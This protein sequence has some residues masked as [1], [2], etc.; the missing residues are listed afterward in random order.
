MKREE[1]SFR[2]TEIDTST[3]S[4][5]DAP[6]DDA[7]RRSAAAVHP[8]DPRSFISFLPVHPRDRA[9]SPIDR[10]SR[11]I[12][13][14]FAYARVEKFARTRRQQLMGRA[15]SISPAAARRERQSAL[16]PSRK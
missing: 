16:W 5:A 3:I 10:Q 7:M 6:A 1:E 9:A 8:R 4:I 11:A 13:R 2:A 12:L 15:T 14:E